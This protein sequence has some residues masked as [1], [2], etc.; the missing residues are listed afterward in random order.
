M[1]LE[2]TLDRHI[3]PMI[4]DSG[5]ANMEQMFPLVVL[6]L[7]DDRRKCLIHWR[8]LKT[9]QQTIKFLLIFR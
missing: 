8:P 9:G 3:Q 5:E 1:R 6:T 7:I 2:S 4:G